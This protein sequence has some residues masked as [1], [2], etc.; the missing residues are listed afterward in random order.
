MTAGD[1]ETPGPAVVS[2]GPDRPDGPGEVDLGEITCD[3]I[4]RGRLRLWQPRI[5][6]RFS[7]DPL[8]LADFVLHATH[9][10]PGF[11]QPPAHA[12]DIG[13]G[14]GVV[15]LA[16]A[17]SLPATQVTLVELQP[18]LAALSRKNIVENDLSG[19]CR[20][21]QADV[22]APATRRLLPGAGFD[23]VASCPPYYPLGQGGVN[24]GSEEAIARH[25]LR[26]P[27]PDLVRASRRLLGFR[28]RLA[29]VYP[30]PRL[31]E[32]LAALVECGLAPR[33]M[34]LVHPFRGEPAQRVLIEAQ[35]GARGSLVI[36]PPLY[37]RE[38]SGV[39][40]PEARRA[41]GEPT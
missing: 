14:V 29:L 2:D 16:L 8:L 25:E 15:G 24:P 34:R 37:L 12:A 26:L 32:L 40:T 7:V 33:R 18:R 11:G 4:L 41:L 1:S 31:P 35:K 17:V 30:S 38:D 21:V 19:R 5:G 27:L 3:P 28:G 20:V 10:E 23:L 9:P 6:Y 36:E 39:Y 22:L 13:A